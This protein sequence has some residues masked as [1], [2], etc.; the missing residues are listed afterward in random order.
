M[1]QRVLRRQNNSAAI[2]LHF[3]FDRKNYEHVFLNLNNLCLVYLESGF[4]K[5]TESGAESGAEFGVEFDAGFR[6]VLK[7]SFN[8]GLSAFVTTSLY[9][10]LTAGPYG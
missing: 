4:F 8:P 3:P 5:R 6:K 7:R 9:F 2:Q 1:R 10:C